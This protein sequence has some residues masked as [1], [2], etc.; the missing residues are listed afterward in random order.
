VSVRVPSLFKGFCGRFQEV[1]QR[2]VK[3]GPTTE[4]MH[5]TENGS[6]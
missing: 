2:Y 1:F 3:V 4:E 5:L 6:T